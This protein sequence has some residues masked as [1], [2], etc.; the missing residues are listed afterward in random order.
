MTANDPIEAGD[1][2]RDLPEPKRHDVGKRVAAEIA[3]RLCDEKQNDRPTDQEADGVD[4]AVEARQRHQTRNAKEAGRAHIVAREREAIL[5]RRHAAAGSVELIGGLCP[6]RR[7]YR[8]PEREGDED[9]EE[10]NGNGVRLAESGGH[11]R[12]ASTA[13]S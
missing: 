2:D 13:E 10:R 5:Q 3:Q 6:A 4:Q 12:K 1:P 7:P 8:D 11:R 9:H